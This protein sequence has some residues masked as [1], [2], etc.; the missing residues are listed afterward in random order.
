MKL[1]INSIIISNDPGIIRLNGFNLVH[2]DRPRLP[3]SNE[4]NMF[5]FNDNMYIKVDNI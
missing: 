1:I 3:N 4:R 5:Y 2:T